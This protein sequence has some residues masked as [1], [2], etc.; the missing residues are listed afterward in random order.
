[1]LDFCAE[2]HYISEVIPYSKNRK[3]AEAYERCSKRVIIKYRFVIDIA[4]LRKLV[5]ETRKSF[6][7]S[8]FKGLEEHAEKCLSALWQ[9]KPR[10]K[11]VCAFWREK[12]RW[13][14]SGL[15]LCSSGL[16]LFACITKLEAEDIIKD[17]WALAREPWSAL[18]SGSPFIQPNLL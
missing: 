12:P 13:S 15:C 17:P 2:H 4:S 18:V 16:Y 14:M 9:E 3:E 1:M 5:A 6:S 7:F 10:M 8:S 11:I